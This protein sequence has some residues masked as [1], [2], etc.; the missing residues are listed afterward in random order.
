MRKVNVYYGD[1][2]QGDFDKFLDLILE[3][4]KNNTNFPALPVALDEISL[5]KT[6]WI[7]ELAKSQSGDHVATENARLIHDDLVNKVRRNGNYI[8]DTAQGDVTKLETSGYTLAKEPE[9][10][11]KPDIKIVQD[12]TSGAGNVVIEAHFDAICYFVE[13][14]VDPVPAPGNNSVWWRLKLSS[15]STLPF[16]GL[17][18]SKLYYMR[19]CY[20]TSEGE[21]ETSQPK[22][23]RVI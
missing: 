16:S 17:D 1:L 18:P 7:K 13:F 5:A 8:N 14:C 11:P 9:F 10:Q 21:S 20:L 2:S 19:Y 15:K 22:S 12:K 4:L 23:F 6:N 3:K